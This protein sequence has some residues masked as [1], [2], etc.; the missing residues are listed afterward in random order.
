MLLKITLKC[1][2]LRVILDLLNQVVNVNA[3]WSFQPSHL[4]RLRCWKSM[5][6][7]SIARVNLCAFDDVVSRC[8]REPT[9]C[10]VCLLVSTGFPVRSWTFMTRLSS[11]FTGFTVRSEEPSSPCNRLPTISREQ[12]VFF[13]LHR[14]HR[15]ITN[16]IRFG[17]GWVGLESLTRGVSPSDCWNEFSNWLM[18]NCRTRLIISFS[19][20]VIVFQWDLWS[21][22]RRQ[23]SSF[24]QHLSSFQSFS[25]YNAICWKCSLKNNCVR[26]CLIELQSFF[27][28]K[29]NIDP[30]YRVLMPFPCT[31]QVSRETWYREVNIFRVFVTFISWINRQEEHCL[32]SAQIL[33]YKYQSIV[34]NGIKIECAS[35]VVIVREYSSSNQHF[36]L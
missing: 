15:S 30:K 19:P 32:S 25:F 33:T 5:F 4:A 14:F 21:W 23:I 36:V 17:L 28:R 6:S 29:I 26:S 27:D 31:V 18:F 13:L 10:T 8:S 11:H 9:S 22:S 1:L 16:W 34:D 35:Y 3:M 24:T 12:D 20:I 7:S 2:S